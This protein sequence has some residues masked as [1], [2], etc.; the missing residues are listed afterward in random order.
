MIVN[1][2]NKYV[3]NRAVAEEICH[4]VY[5]A[6]IEKRSKYSDKLADDDLRRWVFKVAKHMALNYIYSGKAKYEIASEMTVKQPDYKEKDV[7][8]EL[9]YDSIQFL[10]NI[11]QL[12]IFARLD[13]IP[14]EILEKTTGRSRHALEC[15]YSRA[16]KKLRAVISKRLHGK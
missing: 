11:E 7:L 5:L 13:S 1:Y 15:I 8:K 10:N 3:Q 9:L 14:I 6:Y 12:V 2:V 16:V 4:D